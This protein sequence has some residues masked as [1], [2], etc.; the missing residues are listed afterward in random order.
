MINSTCTTRS[1]G[2][3]AVGMRGDTQP[4]SK[5]RPDRHPDNGQGRPDPALW[6]WTLPSLEASDGDMRGREIP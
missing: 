4:D 5:A 6:L 3:L 1:P 2:T